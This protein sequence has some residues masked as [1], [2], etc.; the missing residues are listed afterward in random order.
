MT[1]EIRKEDLK[2]ITKSLSERAE[3]L[4]EFGRAQADI[5]KIGTPLKKIVG[6]P[7]TSE[8]KSKLI[9]LGTS[10]FLFPDPTPITPV[11]G[12][13]MV[14]AGLLE[15][16]YGKKPLVAYDTTRELTESLKELQR[17]RQTFLQQS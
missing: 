8:D 3:T 7:E 16:K 9:K 15:R 6:K 2:K 5:S 13:A 14:A 10:I 12:A 1:L 17:L 11:I 4:E